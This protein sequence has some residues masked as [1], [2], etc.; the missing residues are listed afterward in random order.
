MKFSKTDI[1]KRYLSESSSRYN[2]NIYLSNSN[3]EIQ[4]HKITNIHCENEEENN[5]NQELINLLRNS[6]KNNLNKKKNTLLT[7]KQK[8]SSNKEKSSLPSIFENN[9]KPTINNYIIIPGNNENLIKKCLDLRKNWKEIT[10]KSQKKNQLICNLFWTPL[11]WRIN[12]K[13][14]SADNIKEIK[15]TNH[16]EFHNGI[17]NKYKL[18]INLL[19]YCEEHSKDLFD[20]YPLTIPFEFGHFFFMDQMKS[21]TH[22]FNNINEIIGNDKSRKKYSE[23]FYLNSHILNLGFKTK[24]FIPKNF[25]IGKNLWLV[26]AINMNRGR[27]IQICNSIEK[28]NSSIKNFYAGNNTN[29][30]QFSKKAIEFHRKHN[31]GL[32]S[33]RKFKLRNFSKNYDKDYVQNKITLSLED[34]INNE[35]DE[36]KENNNK[37]TMKRVLLQKYLENP[38][39]Y[40][41]RKFDMRIWVLLNHEMNVYMF[42]E[43]H[44]KATSEKFNIKSN[45][46]FIHLT[47]YSVQKYNIHF[48][49]FEYG[50]E[51]S[52]QQFQNFLDKKMENENKM[53]IDFKNDILPKV[54]KII[55]LSMET[56]KETI[57]ENQRKFCFELFGY[58]FIF[59]N[60]FNP[61]LLEINTNPGLEESSPLINMLIPR[62]IDDLF[63]LTIDKIFVPDYINNKTMNY[64]SPFKVDGHDD[65]ENL[66]EKI[67]NIYIRY[68]LRKILKK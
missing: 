2:K 7:P 61:Y 56:I 55:M 24:F 14:Y 35:N 66:W 3:Y 49:E 6:Y 60:D 68:E 45:N 34:N 47:N 18:F 25:Y 10:E 5:K 44:L 57:N 1:Y 22:L 29:K 19:K 67:G 58:D 31:G 13:D 53:K 63:R 39:L 41:G 26:K 37:N 38:L 12:F 51:I 50:N 15:F 59:D 64:I 30:S 16:F 32:I 36:Q 43:G 9:P 17:T 27:Y 48:S 11:S 23:Y 54:K 20:F 42:K 52:F 65:K 40:N 62:M 33:H 21:F 4:H 28:I 46:L 8:Q